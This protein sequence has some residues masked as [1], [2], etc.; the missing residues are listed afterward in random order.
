MNID[1]LK[2]IDAALRGGEVVKQYFGQVLETEEKS[3]VGDLRTKADVESEQAIIKSLTKSFPDFNIYAEE[4]GKT[5]NKSEYTFVIDPLDGT[6]NFVMGIPDFA[7]SIGLLKNEEAIFGVIYN[8]V[9]DQLY[10][11]EKDKGAF[12]NGKQIHVNSE[13]DIK[14]STISY[15]C[16]YN[17]DQS[18]SD[19][20]IN[21]LRSRGVKRIIDHWAPAFDYCLLASG[22][23]EA[24]ISKEGDLEDYVA[25]KLI[26]TEAGG[27][28]TDFAGVPELGRNPNFVAT[29]GQIVHEILLGI[30]R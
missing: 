30:A 12:L 10:T 14:R 7:V 22:R 16:G 24:V 8:P 15:T 27:K 6:N 5:D 19:R 21:E 25:A 26:V 17:T 11:A 18:Y 29:N 20:V 4:S 9:I 13:T 2:I 28:V 1:T 3:N 23:I